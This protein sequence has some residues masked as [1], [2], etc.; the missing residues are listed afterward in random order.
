M[1]TFFLQYWQGY[2]LQWDLAYR[3]PFIR[4]VLIIM[5]KYIG[6]LYLDKNAGVLAVDLAGEPLAHYYDPGLALVS[7]GIKI[8][9]HSY[10]GSVSYP[11]IIRLNLKQYPVRAN[12]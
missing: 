5:K 8:G 12:T 2:T 7:S 11:Y 9:N 3:Y 10:C 1:S 4:K 6:Q